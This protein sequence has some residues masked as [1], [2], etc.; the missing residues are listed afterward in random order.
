M[1][2]KIQFTI[3]LVV[4]VIFLGAVSVRERKHRE[5]IDFPK[6]L[7]TVVVTVDGKELMLQ[8]IAFYIA[9]QE[10]K[11]EKEAKVYNPD[12]TGEYWRLHTNDIFLREEGKQRVMDMA[13]HDEIFY[14]LALAE[15]IVLTEEEEEHLL[16]DQYDFWSDLDDDQRQSL[17]VRE[18]V[19]NESMRKIALAEK[20]QALLS[21]MHDCATESYSV[22]GQ[23]YERML[24][25][26]TVIVD[27]SVWDRVDFGGI[28]VEH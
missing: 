27:E 25:E 14:Q 5:D 2:Q 7:D 10:G 21:A 17:G 4:F 15:D 13:V 1:K 3:A 8:D 22:A 23:A 6:A 20:Y 11:I 28:T 19:M 9:Y 24:E 26:H 16:N 12:D 18:D